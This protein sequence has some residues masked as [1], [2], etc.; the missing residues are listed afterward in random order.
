MAV[1]PP[2]LA[3]INPTCTVC[4]VVNPPGHRFCGTCGAKLPLASEAAEADAKGKGGHGALE[5][6]V[7]GALTVVLFAGGS[8]LAS[9]I[10]SQ[11]IFNQQ[12]TISGSFTS[13]PAS[14]PTAP[15]GQRTP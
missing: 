9:Q 6:V 7:I 8:A 3:R 15:S 13:G 12:A 1:R 11:S 4:G 5:A 10:A 14:S 2:A